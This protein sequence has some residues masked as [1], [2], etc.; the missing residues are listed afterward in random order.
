M[1]RLYVLWLLKYPIFSMDLLTH[2]SFSNWGLVLD[3]SAGEESRN[4]SMWK[5]MMNTAKGLEQH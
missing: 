4:I 2:L 5:K 3:L 1:L